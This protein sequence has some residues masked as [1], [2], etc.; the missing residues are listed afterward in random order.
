MYGLGLEKH[1]P[2][3]GATTNDPTQWAKVLNQYRAAARD[4]RVGPGP[5]LLTE[6]YL[7]ECPTVPDPDERDRGA[8]GAFIW[9]LL[10]I[11]IEA[12]ALIVWWAA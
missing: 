1:L 10:A 2:M 3:L 5:I 7:L 4:M 8:S 11:A 12:I 6:P 9:L